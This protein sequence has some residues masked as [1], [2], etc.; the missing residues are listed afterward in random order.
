MKIVHRNVW[1][2]AKRGPQHEKYGPLHVIF[3]KKGTLTCE[4]WTSILLFS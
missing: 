2:S 1:N 4:M 3:E